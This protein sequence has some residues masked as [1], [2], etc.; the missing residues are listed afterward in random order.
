MVRPPSQM[1]WRIRPRNRGLQQLKEMVAIL[2]IDEN[3][4]LL[5]APRRD[6]IPTASSLD[7]QRPRPSH[8]D[9]LFRC[10]CQIN[11]Q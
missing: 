8:G 1:S 2:V 6:M 11:N 4:A 9:S 7:S 3:L 10:V 5:I